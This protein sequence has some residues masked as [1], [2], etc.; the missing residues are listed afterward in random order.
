MVKFFKRLAKRK[1]NFIVE[2]NITGEYLN[3]TE[4]SHGSAFECH[5]KNDFTKAYESMTQLFDSFGSISTIKKYNINFSG[6]SD[7]K[8]INLNFD[9]LRSF[10][11]CLEC[12]SFIKKSHHTF[13]YS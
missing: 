12:Y 9:N 3:H 6:Q 13:S 5:S 10:R 1:I 11:E 2:I 8:E 7:N 4:F